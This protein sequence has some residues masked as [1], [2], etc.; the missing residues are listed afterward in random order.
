MTKKLLYW[1]MGD[2]TGRIIVATWNWL[3]GLPL[4]M[5]GDI[6]QE[7]AQESLESMQ[8]SVLKL[9]EAAATVMAAYQQAKAIY[10]SK[11]KEFHH[12]ENQ[13]LLAHRNGQ[14]KAAQLAMGHAIQIEGLLPQL[15]ERVEHAEEL[16]NQTKE[17]LTQEQQRVEAYKI[18]MHNLKALA[19]VNK[20]LEAIA[21]T[22][23]SLKLDSARSQFETAQTAIQRQHFKGKAQAELSVNPSEKLQSD[24]DRLTLSEKI[25]HRL[26]Q[27]DAPNPSLS[28]EKQ[29]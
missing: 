25:A 7:V 18:Q 4:E 14:E 22:T 10:N 8:Q 9:T 26:D 5:S 6:A 29:P 12:A 20:A 27:L 2:R 13:A 17:K 11:Q 28:Q 16:V 23:S 1:L 19:D 15:Q 21:Q 24:L 3:W